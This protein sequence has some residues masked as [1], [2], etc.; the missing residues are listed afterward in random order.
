MDLNRLEETFEVIED[1]AER[2]E[3]IIGLGK[4]LLPLNEAEKIDANIVKGCQSLVWL[5][6]EEKEGVYS[7]KADS[8][9]IIVRGLLALVL[10]IF[11]EKKA[12]EIQSIDEK[13]IFNRLGLSAHLSMTRA[14]GL[15]SMVHKI[16]SLTAS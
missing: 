4:N 1:W 9:A 5:T 6:H 16:K 13:E 15:A 14:N 3:I 10:L 7:F 8:D 2:Y 11:N 12:Q